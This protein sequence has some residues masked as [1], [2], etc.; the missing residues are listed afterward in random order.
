[1]VKVCLLLRHLLLKLPLLKPLRLL[2]QKLLPP[3]HQ[4]LL[5]QKRLLGLHP[6]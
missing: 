4:L 6:K 1:V 3:R 2:P 5:L